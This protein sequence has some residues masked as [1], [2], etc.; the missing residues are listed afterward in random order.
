[1]LNINWY[2]FV[3]SDKYELILCF[4]RFLTK[5]K[6][7]VLIVDLSET[8]SVLCSIPKMEE[9]STYE[10]RGVTFSD[11]RDALS[12][13]ADYDYVLIDFGLCC[14]DTL[15]S[16][17]KKV[18]LVTDQQ[19]HHVQPLS[20]IVHV[21]AQH[22]YLPN[23]NSSLGTGRMQDWFLV[24]RDYVGSGM[25][26][27]HILKMLDV[28]VPDEN[29]FTILFDEADYARRLLIQY[30]HKFRFDSASDIKDVCMALIMPEP[31]FTK[32]LLNK[33]YKKAERG[34]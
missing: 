8:K 9:L 13:S 17:C 14:I 4:S 7:K 16:E 21:Y 2:G 29:V 34:K 18:V 28:N 24:V 20:E 25:K 11:E 12:G 27:R 3:G 5:L 26:P 19:M 1:M 22:S 30:E 32:K 23:E 10:F 31:T 33:A 6:K 15:L